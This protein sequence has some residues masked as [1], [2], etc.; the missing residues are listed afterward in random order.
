[1]AGLVQTQNQI[2]F[3]QE[4]RVEKDRLQAVIESLCKNRAENE[5]FR[6]ST[7]SNCRDAVRCVQNDFKGGHSLAAV[8]CPTGLVFDL[9]GQTCNWASQVDNC[10]RLTKPRV[11]YPNQKRTSRSAPMVNCNVAM[12]NALIKSF[13][14]M[15][16]QIA[17]MG[18]MKWTK[19]VKLKVIPTQPP[20]VIRPIV[21]F[22][23]VFAQQT[24]PK[25]LETWKLLKFHR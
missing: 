21:S 16:N 23:T 7:E 14:V 3:G 19:C 22:P 24:E 5:Y 8:R 13:F 4:D 17:L 1:V 20:N 15:I 9:D 2:D 25:F 18:Q 11:I 10:D 6:L 12:A